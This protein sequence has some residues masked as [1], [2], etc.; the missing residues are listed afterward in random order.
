MFY[1]YS[2]YVVDAYNVSITADKP[3]TRTHSVILARLPSP[4]AHLGFL[5]WVVHT[6]VD[7]RFKVAV[8][9]NGAAVGYQ[10][11]VI[12]CFTFVLT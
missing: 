7:E 1:R 11:Q 12:N 4:R 9:K 8:R 6:G 10:S 2:V 3:F 5:K